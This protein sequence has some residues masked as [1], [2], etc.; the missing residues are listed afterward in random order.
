M[1]PDSAGQT[2]GRTETALGFVDGPRLGL[3]QLLTQL[4]DRAQDVMA[5][6]SR[7][8]GLLAANTMIIG[9]LGLPVVLRRTVEAACQ[10]VHARYGALGV[11]APDGGLEEFI[12]VGIDAETAERIGPLPSGK[13]LLGALIDEP[14]PIRLSVMSCDHRSAGF[15][16]DHPPMS[17]FLGVPIRVRDVVFGNLYLT[18]AAGGEFTDEDEQL[19]AALAAN[20][21]VAIDNARLF[22]RAERRQDW[23]QASTRITRQLLSADGEEP[24]ELIAR[25]V[26]QIA[27][28]DIVTVVLPMATGKRLM[29]EVAS[30]QCAEELTGYS[31]AAENTLVRL[32]FESG[33]PL[34]VG[35]VT[36]DASFHVH[37]SDYL[38]IGPVMVLPLVGLQGTRGAL[39]VG[40]L[41][42]RH[43]FD[44]ADLDMAKTF[45]NHA[46]VALE[47]ADSRA[48]Q[49]RVVVLEDRDRIARD[50]HDHVIQRLF[51]AGLSVQSVASGLGGGDTAQ[52]LARVVEDID[53]TIRQIRTS[54]FELRGQLGPQLSTVRV[55]L[56]ETI[57]EVSSSL[58]FDPQL[59]FAGP[60]DSLVP[61]DVD[62][63][64]VAVTRE[65]LANVARHAHA[66][67]VQVT[68]TATPREL[69]LT[70]ADDGVGIGASQ[71]RS[72]LAN[73]RKRAE[74][75]GGSLVLTSATPGVSPSTREGTLL[76]WT[77][78][79]T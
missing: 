58:G 66:S 68:L 47:L 7:L 37:L 64:L 76:A 12:H 22:A 62:A 35:D 63:D 51:A 15:P 69:V 5:S 25:Q 8:R 72:G 3:D 78:P 75:H 60:I 55:R 42:G 50:L 33:R 38:P 57:A 49:Q 29:V 59:G 32:A 31:Y 74:R 43:R 20:A 70:V 16:P 18:E 10:L 30:G 24:L 73:L 65:A 79:L 40:R 23:L 17:S 61:E 28:A 6:Q 27:D 2:G 36:A 56:I 39:V 48:D 41:H 77:I 19:V 34:L 67:K 11:L 52:R 1:S 45:A 13:G 54:I 4:V 44:E 14:N 46:A 26:R 53:D 9:D 71:S 21:G